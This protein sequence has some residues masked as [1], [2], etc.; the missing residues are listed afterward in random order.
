MTDRED[1]TL[2]LAVDLLTEYVDDIKT[3]SGSGQDAGPAIL[4]A[5]LF[6]VAPDAEDLCL[7]ALKRWL[8]DM[9]A[10]FRGVGAF[11]GLGGLL[12]GL[13]A[14]TALTDAVGPAYSA[15]CSQTPEWLAHERWRTNDVSW[16]DYDLFFGP[17]GVIRAGLYPGGPPDMVAPALKHLIS[18]ALTEE[19]EAFRGGP[20]IDQR[21][22]FNIGRVNTGLGHGMAGV[23]S[24]LAHALRGSGYES[25]RPA[26]R[27]ICDW[28][29][30]QTYTDDIGLIT[31]PPVG[32]LDQESFGTRRRQ[33]WCYGTPG[34]SWTLWEAAD[35]LADDAIRELAED[36][37]TSFIAVFDESLH[38]DRD[39]GE[40]LAV[41]HGAAGILA[42]AD[43]YARFTLV[44]SARALRDHLLDYLIDHAAALREHGRHD[45]SL[46]TGAGGVAAVALTATG[47]ERQWLHHIAVR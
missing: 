32:G 5:T 2:G 21:S 9:P 19:L 39:A 6:S 45:M 46:L 4:A 40:N 14:V 15:L 13:R 33:A 18:M 38:L 31:W 25:A 22:A 47:A 27:R 30:A 24:A 35:P 34:V 44:S 10:V 17:A 28:L 7:R 3:R 42:I 26:L 37:M 12:S 8:N 41:C 11:G 1:R 43:A 16:P 23:A 29:V 36:A 20:E